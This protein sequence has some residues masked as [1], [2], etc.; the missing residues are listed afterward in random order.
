M[1]NVTLRWVEA[2]FMVGTDSTG[3]SVP[4]GRSPEDESIFVGIKPSDLLL[5]S[6]ASC[7]AYDVVGIL[8]KQKEPLR[9]LKVECKGD[10]QSEPPYTFT[11]IHIH[12][13]FEGELDP[14]R[15]DKAIRLSEDKY[16][17]VISSLRPG[18]P[19]TSDFEVIE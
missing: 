14:V 12:Y 7:V 1:G 5:L 17:S 15:L 18:V 8:Q 6:V 19:I 13:I 10:Q 4:I 3:H 2:H 11:K 16:C 9:D